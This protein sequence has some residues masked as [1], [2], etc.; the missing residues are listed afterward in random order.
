MPSTRSV[1]GAALAVVAAALVAAAA[2]IEQ[3]LPATVAVEQR[4]AA[5]ASGL[6]LYGLFT[7]LV[8]RVLALFGVSADLTAVGAP[9]GSWLS[10]AA[11]VLP[12]VA[13]ALAVLAVAGSVGWAALRARERRDTRQSAAERARDSEA[14]STSEAGQRPPANAV[15]SNWADAV[16]ADRRDDTSRTPSESAAERVDAGAPE[17]AV[18]SLTRLFRAVRYGGRTATTKRVQR[19]TELA[20]TVRDAEDG[21]DD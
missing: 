19:A 17:D 7:V 16:A 4:P 10:V 11:A 14:D 12:E 8:V 3:G 15:E 6:S 1:G 18:A 21:R 5:D 9:R 20:D 13:A 2:G